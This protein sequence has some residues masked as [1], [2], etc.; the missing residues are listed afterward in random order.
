M[1]T[2]IETAKNG[3]E[4]TERESETA[5]EFVRQRETRRNFPK[6]M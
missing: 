5:G 3:I 6:L 2:A 1:K 4:C